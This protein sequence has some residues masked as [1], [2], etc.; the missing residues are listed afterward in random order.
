MTVWDWIRPIAVILLWM[1]V[2]ALITNNEFPGWKVK[3][4]FLMAAA[5]VNPVGISKGN[6]TICAV[7]IDRRSVGD[8]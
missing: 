7:P 2:G 3:Q 6:K 4:V 5:F 8:L 1:N